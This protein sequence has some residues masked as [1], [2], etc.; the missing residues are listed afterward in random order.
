MSEFSE[1]LKNAW[2]GVSLRDQRTQLVAASVVA[3]GV[4]IAA[5]LALPGSDDKRPA[6][7]VVD[8]AAEAI[9]DFDTPLATEKA[10]DGRPGGVSRSSGTVTRAGSSST[11]TTPAEIA[12]LPPITDT[13]IKVGIA[14]TSNP[15]TTNEA[16]GF[17]AIGQVDQKRGWDALIKEIN[18]D[19][20]Y[21][22]KIVP[23]YLSVT[24][25]EII[26]K[27][28][29]R[30]E[31]EACAHYTQDNKVFMVWDGIIAGE[32]LSECL[33]KAGVPELGYAF[34]SATM[35]KFPYLVAPSDST[36][37]RMA[38]FEVDQ[39]YKNGFFSSFKKNPGTQYSPCN[40][41]Q[42][43]TGK[44]RIGLIRYDEP[45]YKVAAAAMKER[46]AA[47]GLSLC[48][49][50][51]FEI[52]YSSTNVQEMLDDAT[53]VNAAINNCKSRPQGACTHMLF[54]GTTAGSRLTLFYVDGA[55]KQNYRAKLGFNPEDS[56]T[57]VR[58][59]YGESSY[60]Q[61]RESMVVADSPGAYEVETGA[62]GKCKK[63]FEDAGE[64]FEGNAG[65]NKKAQI[66]MYCDPA[67]Y[68]AA[69]IEQAGRSLS[70]DSWMNAVYTMDPVPSVG[71]YVMQ[72]KKGRLDGSSAVRTGRWVTSCN[73]F[74]P[75]T[76][77]TPV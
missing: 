61:F 68:F 64:T 54:L 37:D 2:S 34:D 36:R 25:Q 66:S 76:G 29:E 3:V 52:S 39:L 14:Y 50:C 19:P 9:D 69:I 35:K 27:G 10:D 43:C 28:Q 72:T 60:P 22:R 55:E 47:S 59:F 6:G 13:T 26:S 71:A 58:D 40:D 30:L 8:Q 46:L 15:G 5:V 32:I 23:V 53:E 74:K 44:P 57:A 63:T 16:A 65:S 7:S 12:K 11:P 17:D 62:F 70:L 20:P 67:Y 4:L 73:C 38:A 77:I 49:G 51:E 21:G 24:E 18:A 75:I 1:R 48:S 45:E 56:P 41:V 31:Q 42:P 33:T